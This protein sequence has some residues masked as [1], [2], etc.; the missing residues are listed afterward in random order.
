MH[1]KVF[2]EGVDITMNKEQFFVPTI[3]VLKFSENNAILT[4][5][6]PTVE[7]P[8]DRVDLPDDLD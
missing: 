8:G 3:E 1:K 7:G 4:A 6:N 5:S 2:G